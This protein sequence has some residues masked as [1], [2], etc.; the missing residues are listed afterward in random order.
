MAPPYAFLTCGT[1]TALLILWLILGLF[2]DAPK[3]ATYQ[4]LFFGVILCMWFVLTRAF[5]EASQELPVKDMPSTGKPKRKQSDGRRAACCVAFQSSLLL[6]LALLAFFGA[7]AEAFPSSTADAFDPAVAAIVL[8]FTMGTLGGFLWKL[9]RGMRAGARWPACACGA[10]CCGGS[11]CAF[12]VLPL[13]IVFLGLCAWHYLMKASTA[14]GAPP[15]VRVPI[16]LPESSSPMNVHL[17]CTEGTN[18]SAPTVLFLHGVTGSCLDAEWVRGHPAV[19]AT[20]ARFCAIDRPGYGWSDSYDADLPP[21]FG[22]AAT[23]VKEALSEHLAPSALSPLKL[24]LMFHSL[25]GY[26]AGALRAALAIDQA[27][28]VRGVVAVDAMVPAW[29]GQN[30]SR[31]AAA[32]DVD[33]PLSNSDANIPFWKLVRDAEPTGLVR[34][35]YVSG[36]GGYNAVV[37]WFPRA[38]QPALLGNAMRA[39]Y[40]RAILTE[41]QRWAINCGYASA[42]M[43]D[44]AAVDHMEVLTSTVAG[45][46]LDNDHWRDYGPGPSRT[47]VTYVVDAGHQAMLLKEGPAATVALALVRTIVAV[48]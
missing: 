47:R 10:T 23:L 41:R 15:G 32:C 11:A 18:A 22:T 31:P 48:V 26:H 44:F 3:N 38:V 24:V 34:I 30:T 28:D 46:G 42:G 21:H 5:G 8:L 17:Y 9:R 14:L 2:I 37:L 27:F 7:V 1:G 25:G 40:P 19:T 36:V 16:F 13:S 43:G 6:L 45:S 33:A 4:L 35:M 20:G 29:S 12:V 39:K